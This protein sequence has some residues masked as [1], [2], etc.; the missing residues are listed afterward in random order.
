MGGSHST[1]DDTDTNSTDSSDSVLQTQIALDE[2][3]I[4]NLKSTIDSLN[5]KISSLNSQ[6]GS[7]QTA[8]TTL[9]TQVSQMQAKVD[10][11][12]KQTDDLKK[13]QSDY[14]D[15]TSKMNSFN[16]TVTMLQNE[17]TKATDALKAERNAHVADLQA[18]DQKYYDL[19]SSTNTELS[20][21]K[22]KYADLMK[23][24]GNCSS[25]LDTQGD[26]ID[27]LQKQVDELNSSKD[28]VNQLYQNAQ[29]DLT[30]ALKQN[31]KLIALNTQY[32]A[33][34]NALNVTIQTTTAKWYKDIDTVSFGLKKIHEWLGKIDSALTAYSPDCMKKDDLAKALKNVF[35]DIYKCCE[36]G[37][38]ATTDDTA[39]F[40]KAMEED[41]NSTET[42]DALYNAAGAA[43]QSIKSGGPFDFTTLTALSTALDKARDLIESKFTAIKGEIEGY[44]LSTPTIPQDDTDDTDNSSD[45]PDKQES[46]K[47][48][49]KTQFGLVLIVI[50]GI[51]SLV[52][53]I[54]MYIWNKF[55]IPRRNDRNRDLAIANYN[56]LTYGV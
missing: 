14:Q 19:L 38:G 35:S 42:V 13:A 44:K 25:T 55:W 51:I 10:N 8:N 26:L 27:K 28:Q 29:A 49:D 53:A 6:N 31:D 30:N 50:V 54:G 46:F 22:T 39:E 40:L 36:H 3:T 11:Y 24:Q 2:Q 9:S 48:S 52:I 23:N 32:V 18:R 15:C 34:F 21:L 43:F 47:I 20:N 33:L 1:V 37:A 56:S 41:N 7:L 17:R 4:T 12:D 16:T 5:S 45:Q